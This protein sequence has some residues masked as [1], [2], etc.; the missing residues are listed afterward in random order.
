VQNALLTVSLQNGLGRHIWF[1]QPDQINDALRFNY[2][3]Q[4]WGIAAAGV[5]RISCCVFLL[6]FVSQYKHHR[7]PLWIF[8]I[9]QGILTPFII[10][11][12][13]ASQQRG[14]G[15][16]QAASFLQCTVNSLADLYLAIVPSAMFW[17]LQ[18]RLLEKIGLIALFS[19][20]ILSVVPLLPLYGK[21]IADT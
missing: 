1:L 19:C 6:G 15:F 4:G 21:K 8:A 20:S 2:Y 13:Y 5:A 18:L 3:T 9:L 16:L 10:I 14:I 12:I 11:V 7:W 17:S